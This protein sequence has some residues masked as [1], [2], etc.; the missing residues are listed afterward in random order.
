M[1]LRYHSAT[2]LRWYYKIMFQYIQCNDAT[3]L[4]RNVANLQRRPTGKNVRKFQIWSKKSEIRLLQEK[5]KNNTRWVRLTEWWCFTGFGGCRVSWSKDIWPTD[6]WPKA[7]ANWHLYKICLT[8][9]LTADIWATNIGW[10][11]FGQQILAWQTFCHHT[12]NQE[13]FYYQIFGQLAFAWQTFCQDKFGQHIFCQET[14]YLQIFGRLTLARLTFS[15]YTFFQQTFG[16]KTF[17]HNSFDQQTFGQHNQHN[18][19]S[20]EPLI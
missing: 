9:I 20:H 10:Q 4:R 17:G 13:I 5:K 14:F 7:F 8:G 11:T 1:M 6:I 3:T 18:W 15:W 19:H 2:I 16:P 12:F